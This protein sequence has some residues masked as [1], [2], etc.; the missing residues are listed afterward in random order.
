MFNCVVQNGFIFC[1]QN[2]PNMIYL[3]NCNKCSLQYIGEPAQKL[4]KTFHWN[5][6]GF[7][8]SFSRILSDH[9]HKGVYCSAFFQ[10]KYW[11]K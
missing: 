11:K 2:I 6:T 10:S 1:D 3:I 8:Y 5:E 9:L 4:N 7:K